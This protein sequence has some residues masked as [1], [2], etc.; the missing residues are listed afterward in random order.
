MK[1]LKIL[2]HI[3]GVIAL[4]VLT[5]IGGIAYLIAA[6][7]PKLT[8]GK[9]LA[10]FV[11]TY[12]LLWVSASFLAPVFGRVPLACGFSTTDNLKM[13]SPLYCIMN[14]HYVTPELK[15]VAFDLAGY[16]EKSYP[17]TTTLA[18]DAGFPFFD[19]F[20]LLP[21][22]S[23]KDG[24]KLDIAYYYSENG[25]TRS[26]IGY[27]AFEEPRPGDPQPCQN[28]SGP[29]LRW[30][31]NWLQFTFN[32]LT[33]DEARTRTALN[34]L[35]TEGK[36]RGVSKVFI[37]PHLARRLGVSGDVIRFQGCRAARHDD[38]IHLQIRP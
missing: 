28:L 19:G 17:G 20:A 27:W 29:T 10:A 21:H 16:V 30:N 36:Q 26:P 11:L 15:S 13:Q 1:P 31:M 9:R 22:L 37:E 34:W 24:R 32:S 23:H 33:M 38:H 7:L 18:L 5:Q 25:K 4:T 35:A 12:T 8:A 6:F 3:I 2:I 14:R